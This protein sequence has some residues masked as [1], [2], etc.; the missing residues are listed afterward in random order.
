MI[1]SAAMAKARNKVN[2]IIKILLICAGFARPTAELMGSAPA[3][4]RMSKRQP[5][6]MHEG[7]LDFV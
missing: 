3:H 2:L 4:G 5:D 6:E 7:E 1:A